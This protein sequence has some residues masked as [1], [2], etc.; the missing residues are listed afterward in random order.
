MPIHADDP[1]VL[2]V[3]LDWENKFPPSWSSL[4]KQALTK[5][6]TFLTDLS[7]VLKNS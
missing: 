1:R 2:K 5:Y 7:G 3:I 6:T 4:W